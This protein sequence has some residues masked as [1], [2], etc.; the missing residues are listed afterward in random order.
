MTV[1]SCTE[2]ILATLYNGPASLGE[3]KRLA[4]RH[5]STAPCPWTP[6]DL[7][8]EARI[9]ISAGL[10][11]GRNGVLELNHDRLHPIHKRIIAMLRG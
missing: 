9:L 1:L 7:D 8:R 11:V 2:Y 4:A 5:C 10:L 3:L 6:E